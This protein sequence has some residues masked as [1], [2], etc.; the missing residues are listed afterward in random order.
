MRA[1]CVVGELSVGT[2]RSI[3]KGE[4]VSIQNA[5]SRVKESVVRC[6]SDLSPAPWTT[7]SFR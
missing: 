4:R 3:G 5:L 2:H 7:A 1:V 6:G